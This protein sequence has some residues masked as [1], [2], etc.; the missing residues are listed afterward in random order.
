[1][2]SHG[3]LK[4][5]IWEGGKVTVYFLLHT[6]SYK[7]LSQSSITFALHSNSPRKYLTDV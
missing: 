4:V 2:R 6:T 5:E 1:M 3:G 7:D